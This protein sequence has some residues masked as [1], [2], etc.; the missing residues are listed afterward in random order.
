MIL[1]YN[2]HHCTV[3]LTATPLQLFMIDNGVEDWRLAMDSK[4][5][6]QLLLEVLA[7][8]ICPIPGPFYFEWVTTHT[9]GAT[10]TIAKV[11]VDVLLSIPMFARLYLI[12]RVMLLHSKLFTDASHRSIGA[13]NR[14][15]FNVQFIVKTL[16]TLAPGTVLAVLTASYWVIASWLIML[17][18]RYSKRGFI[19]SQHLSTILHTV[20]IH[21]GGI[22]GLHQTPFQ[23][24]VDGETI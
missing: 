2:C 7:C 8:G 3:D 19:F 4:R 21:V 15:K 1:S 20:P 24:R 9:D 5:L 14:I 22:R 16:M 6:A 23:K 11:P 17:C 18:E 10:V 13:L 12:C